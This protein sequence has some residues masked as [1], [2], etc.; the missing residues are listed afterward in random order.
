MFLE[1]CFTVPTP[2]AVDANEDL[3]PTLT[4]P[5]FQHRPTVLVKTVFSCQEKQLY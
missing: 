1:L 3:S 2:H 5:E 4:R